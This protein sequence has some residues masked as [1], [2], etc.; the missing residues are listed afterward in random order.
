MQYRSK[1]P[2]ARSR[3]STTCSSRYGVRD[4]YAVDNILDLKY[5]DTFIAELAGRP[6]PPQFLRD[7]G[8]PDQAQLR[9][10]ARA[11]AGASSPASRASST[12]SCV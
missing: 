9:P 1:S 4:V 5:L 7:E 12:R 11:G 2:D 8:E 3:R 6:R 10:L